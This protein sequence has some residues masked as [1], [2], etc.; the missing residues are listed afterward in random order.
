MNR[1][2]QLDAN[3]LNARRG[4]GPRTAPGKARVASNALKHG[5]TGKDI[6]LPSENPHRYDAFRAAL[7]QS[8]D[9]HGDL[10][11]L[12]ADKIVADGWRLR[13]IPIL[14]AALHRRGRHDLA[15]DHAQAA[16]RQFR[17]AETSA[18]V[19]A[20]T[21]IAA[22]QSK[23][24]AEV[25]RRL[26]QAQTDQQ[27]LFMRDPVLDATRVLESSVEAFANLWR[28]ERALT[29]SLLRTLHEL[30]RLQAIRAGEF[31]PAPAVIDLNLDPPLARAQILA[32]DPADAPEDSPEGDP[33]GGGEGDIP[34]PGEGDLKGDLPR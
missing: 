16:V 10:E 33:E 2:R 30:Q 32:D 12:L 13:R 20:I 17:T 28:H 1:D 3:R 14:E 29:R 18:M 21:G 15:V 5:L 22:Q 4:T 24:R 9:P 23:A 7:I 6:A 25:E 31:V 19:S 26:Q 27:N 34:C 8:L 11:G